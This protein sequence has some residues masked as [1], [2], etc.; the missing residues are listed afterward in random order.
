M[1]EEKLCKNCI[2]YTCDLA[3]GHEYPDIC[4]CKNGKLTNPDGSCSLWESREEVR[5]RL[6]ELVRQKLKENNPSK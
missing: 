2:S 1:E 6:C 5:E 4:F 3:F